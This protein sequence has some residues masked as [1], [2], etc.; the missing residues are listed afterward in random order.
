MC[1]FLWNNGFR[2]LKN[3]A[4]IGLLFIVGFSYR[5]IRN[6]EYKGIYGASTLNLVPKTCRQC[7]N[8]TLARSKFKEQSPKFQN[9]LNKKDKQ[10]QFAVEDKNEEKYLKL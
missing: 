2:T 9:I 6:L 8:D 7:N 1:Y 10:I 3:S 4:P 5:Y